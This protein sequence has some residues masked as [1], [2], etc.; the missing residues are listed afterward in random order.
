MHLLADLVA[1]IAERDWYILCPAMIS[2]G[3]STDGLPRKCS[4]ISGHQGMGTVCSGCH[5]TQV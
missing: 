5:R 4:I 2:K 1:A 3:P